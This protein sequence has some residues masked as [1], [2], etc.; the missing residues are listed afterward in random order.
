[1]R[2]FSF[3]GI[4]P[5]LLASILFALPISCGDDDDDRGGVYVPPDDDEDVIVPD[6]D[7]ADDDADDD[8]INDDADDD[9]A[10]PDDDLDD[11]LD[12]DTASPDDDSDDDLNDDLNDDLDDDV[13]DDVDDDLEPT[14]ILIPAGEFMMGCSPGDDMCE[15]KEIPRHRVIL[16][17]NFEMTETEITQAQFE[18]V[19]GYN[20]S[21][22]SGCP[23]CP[24]EY[25]TLWDAQDFCEYYG[26]RIP[27]EA[28]WE[29]AARAGVE[30][31]YLCGNDVNCLYDYA[32]FS[33]TEGEVE[34]PQPV[35]QKLPNAFGLYDILGN[36]E[37][38]VFDRFDADYY[39]TRPDPDIDPQG[40]EDDELLRSITRGG[41]YIYNY[42]SDVRLSSRSTNFPEHPVAVIGIRCARDIVEEKYIAYLREKCDED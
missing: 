42:F 28:E 16:T 18:D 26:G 6:D 22:F 40:P 1:M 21:Y 9:T 15:D 12:D 2:G 4:V 11:D 13:D 17:Y 23:D 25:T 14:W 35:R 29:Y 3:A 41:P 31:R 8:S 27:T 34:R 19:M 39:E 20:P 37:E 7:S 32:W 36:V 33:Q 10:S 38:Y 30:T 24:I 5:L